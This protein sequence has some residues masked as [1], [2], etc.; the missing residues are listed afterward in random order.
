MDRLTPA[1]L[2]ELVDRID[3]YETE[4]TGKNHTQ[5]VVIHYRFVGYVDF[6]PC[7]LRRN[8]R[9]DT[10]KGVSVEYIPRAAAI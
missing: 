4:G 2:R 10:R 8:I 5:R 1:L 7:K 9:T 6:Q 3:V